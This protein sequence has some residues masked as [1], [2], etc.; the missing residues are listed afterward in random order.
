[1]A[2]HVSN[3][4]LKVLGNE[5]KFTKQI[6]FRIAVLKNRVSLFDFVIKH[7][8]II[9]ITCFILCLFVL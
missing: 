9:M 2:K 8:V 1:M 6:E 4:C 3:K 5:N 7:V